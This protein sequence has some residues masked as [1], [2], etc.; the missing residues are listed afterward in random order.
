MALTK[1]LTGAIVAI[2]FV[3]TTIIAFAFKA[4]VK[5]N[6]KVSA[7]KKLAVQWVFIGDNTGDILDYTKYS[8]TETPSDDC[9]TGTELPCTVDFPNGTNTPTDL[10]TYL[11]APGRTNANI[12]ALSP[13]KRDVAP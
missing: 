8:K 2:A 11:T 7:G 4:D 9:G 13:D 1:K 10:Q 3:L 5:K 12:L 6:E